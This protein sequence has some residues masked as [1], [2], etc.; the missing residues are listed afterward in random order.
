VH[1]SF[2]LHRKHL[3]AKEVSQFLFELYQ[4]DAPGG[5]ATALEREVGLMRPPDAA[6]RGGG[7]VC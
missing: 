4:N 2:Q 7:G 6:A 1:F 3:F 5:G